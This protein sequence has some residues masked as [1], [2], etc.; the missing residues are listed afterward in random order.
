MPS[1]SLISPYFIG[2]FR[3]CHFLKQSWTLDE[4][5]YAKFLK[6]NRLCHYTKVCI[7]GVTLGSLH[8]YS[9]RFVLCNSKLWFVEKAT[10]LTLSLWLHYGF[11]LQIL[12][13][14]SKYLMK[15][16]KPEKTHEIER[17]QR[18]W[19]H[20]H[21]SNSK[22]WSNKSALQSWKISIFDINIHK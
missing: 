14:Y 8:N 13:S 15:V 19:G 20:F 7:L 16:T 1:V 21:Y 12:I 9:G 22:S 5:K 10:L 3:F 2:F 17:N 11:F 4:P 6:K 18:N